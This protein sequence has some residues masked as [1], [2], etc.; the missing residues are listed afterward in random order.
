MIRYSI[1]TLEK[2]SGIKAHTIRIWEQ[3]Y[4]VLQPKRTDTNIRYYDDHQMKK[5]LNIVTLL[6]NGYRISKISEL[7]ENELHDKVTAIVENPGKD[8]GSVLAFIN[9][10][11]ASGLTLD[12]KTFEST[13]QKVRREFN[14]EDTYTKVLQPMLFKVGLMWTKGKMN[15]AQEHFLSNLVRQKIHSAIDALPISKNDEKRWL[16][17]LPP[18]EYHDVGLL[19][20]HFL[21]RKYNNSVLYLGA[22]VPV[23]DIK[24]VAEAYKPTHVLFFVIKNMTLR[25]GQRF[26][27]EVTETLSDSKVLLSGNFTYINKL[28]IGEQVIKLEGPEDFKEHYL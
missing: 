23:K 28:E 25:N 20:A 15:P 26:M 24:T 18:D 13:F 5:L 2:L 8:E 27:D 7:S 9:K 10:L 19:Y 17:F 21:L 22:S 6:H 11:I 4:R 1:S 12:L 3:R 14:T 16:L